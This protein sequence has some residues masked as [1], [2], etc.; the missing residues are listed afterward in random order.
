MAA[1]P[2]AR[3]TRGFH[4]SIPLKIFIAASSI[5]A[6]LLGAGSAAAQNYPTRPI[7][8]VVP[9]TAGGPTDALMRVPGER[10]RTTL[11]EPLRVENVTGAA[12]TM[13]LDNAAA[14]PP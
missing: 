11:G 12:G 14:N 10:M 1:H 4:E 8:V 3:Q 9:F 2:K 5:A 6:A 7:V 13:M